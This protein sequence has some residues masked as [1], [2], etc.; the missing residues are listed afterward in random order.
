LGLL[1]LDHSSAPIRNAT[2]WRNSIGVKYTLQNDSV[3]RI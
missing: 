1:P 2:L 3:C